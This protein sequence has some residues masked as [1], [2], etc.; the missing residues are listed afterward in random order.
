MEFA[1]IVPLLSAML[2]GMIKFG[3]AHNNR[4]ALTDASRAAVRELAVGR[5]SATAYTDTVARFHASA[6]ILRPAN[7]SL[8]LS[9]NGVACGSDSA[10]EAALEIASGQAAT[11]A[12]TFPCDLTVMGF[13]FA[14]GCFLSATTSARIE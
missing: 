8:T 7:V 4:I 2:F 5:E 10:C 14:P 6:G 3:V 9:V 1:L 13:D 12:A 11:L